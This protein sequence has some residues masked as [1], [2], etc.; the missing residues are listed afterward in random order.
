MQVLLVLWLLMA[1]MKDA[2]WDGNLER[3]A[4][5]PA[6]TTTEVV[7]AEGPLGPPPPKP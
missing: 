7:A 6:E 2:T 1:G 5:A 3:D 4:S